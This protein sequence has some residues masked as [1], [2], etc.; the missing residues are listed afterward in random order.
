MIEDIRILTNYSIYACRI[1]AIDDDP[2]SPEEDNINLVY[3]HI[4]ST[5]V[6]FPG[7]IPQHARDLLKRILVLDPRKGADLFE[8]ARH[9]W[10]NQYA[11]ILRFITSS[12]T[13]IEDISNTTAPMDNHAEVH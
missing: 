12:E 7:Y 4:G 2:T 8:V 10:L 6:T 11:D 5:P 3:R 13:T 1:F 9:S